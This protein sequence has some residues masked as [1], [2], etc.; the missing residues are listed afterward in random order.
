VTGL[1][2]PPHALAE[3]RR[4][5]V[6][7]GGELAVRLSGDRGA[8]PML[9][10][11]GLASNARTWDE[12]AAALVA[13][14][15]RTVAVDLRD[16]GVSAADGPGVSPDEDA[17]TTA[18]GD[19][20]ALCAALELTRPVVA[21]QSWGGN[22]VLELAA[23]H[24]EVPAAVALVDG[25]WIHLADR[26]DTFSD[27]WALLAPP[28]L[29]RYTV[30]EIGGWMRRSH[31]D[32]SATAV[33]GTLANLRTGPDGR[34]RARLTRDHHRA[35]LHSLW[36]HR[37]RDRYPS[38]RVPALLLPAVSGTGGERSADTERLVAEAA[39]AL[40]DARV[41]RF[42]DADH[43]LHCQHPVAVADEL[44]ALA[45]AAGRTPG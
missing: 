33:A 25:G 21:G 16:H 34:A 28:D 15:F 44:C 32:W 23:A 11:H 4:V 7:G 20:A 9:L 41:Q 26:F 19:L 43:D 1:S 3:E 12:V 39:A 42:T 13:R 6:P 22:V 18:A 17:T 35:V 10:V 30:E 8:P 24:P 45:A 29:T 5:A 31:P 14:G 2:T 40:P 27:C 38:V 36:R 37:P